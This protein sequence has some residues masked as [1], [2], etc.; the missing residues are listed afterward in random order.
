M[1]LGALL[2]VVWAV[3]WITGS[4]GGILFAST[5]WIGFGLG[6]LWKFRNSVVRSAHVAEWTGKA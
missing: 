1:M 6:A 4:L 2:F 5:T 3:G